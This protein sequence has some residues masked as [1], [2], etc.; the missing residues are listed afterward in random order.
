[1]IMAL[2]G[3]STKSLNKNAGTRWSCRFLVVI[4]FVCR[5]NLYASMLANSLQSA[6]NGVEKLERGT[7]ADYNHFQGALKTSE[8]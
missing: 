7:P 3:P 6:R 4:V 1:M 8:C 5:G 2:K